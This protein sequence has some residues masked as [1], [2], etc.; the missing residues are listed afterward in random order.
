LND[1]NLDPE[2]E[3]LISHVL[4]LAIHKKRADFTLE[5]VLKELDEVNSIKLHESEFL[6]KKFEEENLITKDGQL[7]FLGI[8]KANEAEKLFSI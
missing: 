5:D 7:T 3:K 6:L 4:I 2:E 8:A 1:L